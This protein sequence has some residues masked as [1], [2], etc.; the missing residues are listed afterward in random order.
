M[1]IQYDGDIVKKMKFA[2]K[3]ANDQP[4]PQIWQFKTFNDAAALGIEL[5]WEYPNYKIGDENI[6]E[7]LVINKIS[8][9]FVKITFD[10]YITTSDSYNLFVF[11]HHLNYIEAIHGNNLPTPIPQLIETDWWTEK[12]SIIFL[13]QSVEFKTHQPFAQA[14]CVPQRDSALK[15]ME[16]KEKQRIEQ[17]NA[18]LNDNK[19]DYI[20]REVVI[21]NYCKQDN[22]YERLS[23][24]NKMRELP[25]Q[26]KVNKRSFKE[27]LCI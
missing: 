15:Q 8:D 19:H 27:P 16:G 17:V 5:T 21:D 22:L 10:A 3:L 26:I 7:G 13:N 24:L 6:P 2:E 25:S 14:I 18:W 23:A 1:I 9:E 4:K 11:P 12:V 20:T